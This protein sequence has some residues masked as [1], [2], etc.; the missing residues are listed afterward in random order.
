MKTT[1][2]K[3]VG[4]SDCN[5]SLFVKL[6]TLIDYMQDCS[7]Y[8]SDVLGAGV[9]YQLRTRR[10][11]ILS[12]WQIEIDEV[13]K[14]DEELEVSTW[15]YA[16]K[17]ACGRRNYAIAKADNP[18]QYIIRADSVWAMFDSANHRLTRIVDDDVKVYGSEEPLNMNYVK[19]KIEKVNHFEKAEE[20]KV[21]KY[22]LDMNNHM[23][24]AWYIKL[25]EEII[26]DI[27]KVCSI[28]V[29][30]KK[31]A[32]YDDHIIA[33][34]SEDERRYLIELRDKEDN[35]YTIIEFGKRGMVHD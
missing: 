12:S 18:E 13:P 17:A 4:F 23:N 5:S 10:A 31:S 28:R 19:G 24:N 2:H 1:I 6:G 14:Y 26:E 22:Q 8:Q 33:W 21:R 25:A 7:N 27:S 35:L 29:E 34:T 3:K 20:F 30:Y 11:W 32:I 16:F 15:A 9:E